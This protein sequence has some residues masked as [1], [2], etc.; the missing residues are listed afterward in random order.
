[1]L[2]KIPLYTLPHVKITQLSEV[3]IILPILQTI[4]IEQLNDTF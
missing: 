1:M 4:E 2:Y 3:G